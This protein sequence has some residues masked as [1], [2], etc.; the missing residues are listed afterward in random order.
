MAMEGPCF[1]QRIL[2]YW[3]DAQVALTPDAETLLNLARRRPHPK[4]QEA[5]WA[6]CGKAQMSASA[7][8]FGISGLMIAGIAS[9]ASRLR[10]SEDTLNSLRAEKRSARAPPDQPD[11]CPHL[12]PR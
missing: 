7:L 1:P 4:K 10:F 6:R 8:T 5:A 9:G 11:G 3:H 2:F 12:R